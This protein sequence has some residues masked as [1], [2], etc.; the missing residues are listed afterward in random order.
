MSSI[1]APAFSRF[2]LITQFNNNISIANE[3]RIICD[4]RGN[5]P[6]IFL[7]RLLAIFDGEQNTWWVI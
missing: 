4:V 2:I 1:I 3:M 5:F 6:Q 7:E